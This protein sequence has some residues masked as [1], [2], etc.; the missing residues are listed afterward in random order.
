MD[1]TFN[2]SRR[3]DGVA[4]LAMDVP[5]ESMNTLRAEFGPE[6]SEVLAEIKADKSIKGLVLI[7]GK[8]R[9]ICCR[10]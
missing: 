6:I 10:C 4:I 2:L 5:G 7:S 1:K 9:L 8:K 3:D